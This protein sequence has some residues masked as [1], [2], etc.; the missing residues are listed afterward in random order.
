MKILKNGL[1]A[2]LVM[3]LLAMTGMMVTSCEQEDV[4]TVFTPDPAKVTITANVY[5]AVVG[6]DVT[7]LATIT[8]TGT[9]EY[10]KGVTAGTTVTVS[11]SYNG[12]T[13][14]ETVTLNPLA[15]GGVATYH[16]NIIL[17]GVRPTPDPVDDGHIVVKV[18]S[19][20]ATEVFFSTPNAQSHKHTYNDAVW[21]EN[22]T[23]YFYPWTVTYSFPDNVFCSQKDLTGLVDDDVTAYSDLIAAMEETKAPLTGVIDWK[24][25]AW[26]LSRAKVTV[27]TVTTN[28]EIKGNVTGKVCGTFTLVEKYASAQGEAEEIAHPNHASHYQYGHAHAHSHG[29]GTENAGGGI[30]MAD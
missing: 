8:G 11:A 21:F 29:H 18:S 22:A 15:V 28:Y 24:A 2:K 10:P 4:D 19:T 14:S 7:S 30:V 1:C 27:T 25:S 9:T 6:Q 17:D 13:G 3:A 23:D 16:V 26:S 12:M 20:I 5:D